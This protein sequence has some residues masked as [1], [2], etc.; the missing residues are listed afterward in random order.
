MKPTHALSGLAGLLCLRAC[1]DVA[2]I[3]DGPAVPSDVTAIADRQIQCR[4]WRTLEITDE[5]T[6]RAAELA[7][8]RLRC[9]T[10][11]TDMSILRNKYSQSPATLHVLNVAGN[12]GP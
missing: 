7:L 6:D 3:A 12:T 4:K 10:L 1:P 8:T 5:A 9:D 11:A 2:A